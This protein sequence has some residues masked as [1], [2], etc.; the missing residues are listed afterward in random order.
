MAD[1]LRRDAA[2]LIR[3]TQENL[4][5]LRPRVDVDGSLARLRLFAIPVGIAGIAD[6]IDQHLLEQKF[7]HH[8]RGQGWRYARVDLHAFRVQTLLHHFQGAAYDAMERGRCHPLHIGL[9]EHAHVVD[10][11]AGAVD[12][13]GDPFQA[14]Q[15]RTD[16]RGNALQPHPRAFR[17]EA[18]RRQRLAEFMPDAGSQLAQTE[19]SPG[20]LQLGGLLLL[21]G[22]LLGVTGQYVGSVGLFNA[23]CRV[24]EPEITP[25]L[26]TQAI[27]A[28]SISVI[29]QN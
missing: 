22:D 12:H 9:P 25:F 20:F 7:R 8:D 23:G 3:D 19:H 16:L 26:V 6:Q 21:P 11:H 24:A 27:F 10:N 1:R 13:V 18:D 4:P 29:E 15:G 5:V 14:V 2:S 28:Q 17:R